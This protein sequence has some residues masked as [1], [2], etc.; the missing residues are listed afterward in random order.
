MIYHFA[1][2]HNRYVKLTFL[3]LRVLEAIQKLDQY[4]LA[5]RSDCHDYKRA[6]TVKKLIELKF[7]LIK[8]KK[9]GKL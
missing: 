3:I 7:M 6:N 8:K 9:R 4:F 2:N 5:R 1:D